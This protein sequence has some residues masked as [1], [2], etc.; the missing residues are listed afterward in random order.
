MKETKCVGYKV[1]TR[2]VGGGGYHYYFN[3]ALQ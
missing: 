2:A 1:L 3:L